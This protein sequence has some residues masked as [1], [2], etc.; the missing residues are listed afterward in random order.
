MHRSNNTPRS[1]SH[2]AKKFSGTTLCSRAG[3]GSQQINDL[4]ST[5]GPT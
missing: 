4:V 5:D 1:A 2:A 3:T